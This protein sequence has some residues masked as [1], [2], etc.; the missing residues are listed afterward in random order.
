MEGGSNT[1]KFNSNN[2]ADPN[3]N[4]DQAGQQPSTI[5]DMIA[6]S[7]VVKTLQKEVANMKGMCLLSRRKSTL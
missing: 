2:G 3:Q 6:K 7:S 4:G 1:S 5:D